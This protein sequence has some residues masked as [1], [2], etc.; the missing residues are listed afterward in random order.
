MLG[1]CQVQVQVDPEL[2]LPRWERLLVFVLINLLI[3]IP[4]LQSTSNCCCIPISV[5]GSRRYQINYSE[6]YLGV[7]T[8]HIPHWNVCYSDSCA[9]RAAVP[10]SSSVIVWVLFVTIV[11]DPCIRLIDLIGVWCLKRIIASG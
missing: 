5:R 6:S 9:T 3:R 4:V 1:L 8:N 11:P 2:L 7:H 10:T